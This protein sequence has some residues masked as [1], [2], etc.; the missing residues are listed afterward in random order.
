MSR[1]GRQPVPLAKGVEVKIADGRVSVKGPKG[2]L[3]EAVAPHCRVEVADGE[4][5]I[6]REGEE[7]RAK[8][9]HGLMRALIANM[10]K[11]VTEGFSRQLD[12]VGVGYR[13]EVANKNLTLTIFPTRYQPIRRASRSGREPDSAARA[14][15]SKQQVG[16]FAAEIR[17]CA[18]LSRTRARAFAT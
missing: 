1:I 9:M 15:A 5:V 18:S 13:A 16:Q 6:H 12:I 10:V 7:K 3:D 8:A 17:R 14:R 11:G 2:Q 4:V